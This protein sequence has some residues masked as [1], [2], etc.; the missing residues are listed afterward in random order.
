MEISNREKIVH[1]FIEC[2]HLSGSAIA[3]QLKLPKSTVCRVIKQYKETLTIERKPRTNLKYGCK[4]KDLEKKVLKSIKQN[5][6]LSDRDRAK[7]Y[8]CPVSTARLIRVRAGIRAYR[9]IKHPNRSDKQN[10]TAKQRARKLY[11]EILTK[12]NGCIMQDDE[13]YVKQ[14]F[15]QLPGT[16]FY[17]SE[18]RGKAPEKFKYKKIDKFG[19][20]FMIWQALCSCGRKSEAL[21]TSGNMTADTYIEL[22]LKQRILPLMRAHGSSASFP[23]FWP[24][25]ASVHYAKKV[26]DWCESNDIRI[27]P[28]ALNPPN[29]P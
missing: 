29:C 24:D 28:K 10:V 8:G 2:P 11:D 13:T 12:H 4:N 25:L 18:G 20:K 7:K 9:A 22:C 26:I 16:K 21:V 19:K 3:K 1:K 17:Y 6:G 15:S 23:L 14:S 27:L 5:P